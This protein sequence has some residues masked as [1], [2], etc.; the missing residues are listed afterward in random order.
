VPGGPPAV[1]SQMVESAV[2]DPKLGFDLAFEAL[3]E[4]ADFPVAEA[5]LFH[6]MEDLYNLYELAK[7][8]PSSKVAR[9]AALEAT[10]DGKIALA[11]AWARNFRMH[12]VA[13]VSHT[14]DLFS[15]YYTNLYGV[16]VWRRRSDF[17]TA[18]DGGGRHLFYD[19]NLEGR[20]VLDTLQTAVSA[21]TAVIPVCDLPGHMRAKG[22]S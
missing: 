14:G 22:A 17:T 16:L 19:T 9:D 2:P 6:A 15:D 11:I 12:D 4:A 3:Y 10:S 1:V 5:H 7:Q 21:V 18:T 20:P 13:E 8:H